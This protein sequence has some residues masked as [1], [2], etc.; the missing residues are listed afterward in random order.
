MVLFSLRRLTTL[1]IAISAIAVLPLV[2]PRLLQWSPGD[3]ATYWMLALTAAGALWVGWLT[4]LN[5][6]SEQRP[7]LI[8]TFED[9]GTKV[10]NLG[11]GASLNGSLTGDAGNR[12]ARFADLASG[13]TAPVRHTMDWTITESRFL[14]YQDIAGAWFSTKCL[15]Q[16]ATGAHN[17]PVANLFLGRVFNPPA[18]ARSA[19]TS[20]SAIE[21]LTQLNRWWDPRNWFRRIA[22]EVKLWRSERR[23][24]EMITASLKAGTLTS[25]FTSAEVSRATGMEG[26]VADRFLPNHTVNNPGGE[27]E[28]FVETE[29][30]RFRLKMKDE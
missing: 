6:R 3:Q 11:R 14:F 17:L 13:E 25:P 21:H 29:N 24:V 8:V 7:I 1:A 20:R 2:V 22:Y 28:F 12:L 30:G 16:G 9:G 27:R 18:S 5:L 10:R 4:Y 23:L 26:V 19:A 15:G